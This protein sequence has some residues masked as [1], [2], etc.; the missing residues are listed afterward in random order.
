M[1]CMGASDARHPDRC[2][3]RVM[4]GQGSLLSCGAGASSGACPVFGAGSRM[5]ERERGSGY[6]RPGI[7]PVSHARGWFITLEGPEGAGKTTQ[8]VAL[9]DHLAAAGI[10]VH[11]TREP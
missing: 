2:R 7:P 10:E 3:A 11:L 6:T 5:D 9:A 4:G 8:A 1:V